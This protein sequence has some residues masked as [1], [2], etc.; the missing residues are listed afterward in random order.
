M[1]LEIIVGLVA[2]AAV[3]VVAAVVVLRRRQPP[4][5]GVVDGAAAAGEAADR[6]VGRLADRAA[7]AAGGPA[8]SLRDRLSKAR[9]VLSGPLTALERTSVSQE[10]WTE[11]TEA[12]IRADVGLAT[13]SEIVEAAR[14]RVGSVGGD[15]TAAKAALQTELRERLGGFDRSLARR[16]DGESPS[17]WLFVGVNGTG[18]TT[19]IGKLAKREA[20]A[21][22]GVVLAAGD[23]FRAAAADQLAMWA[24][25]SS[26]HIVRG[27]A[28][29]DPASVV[30]DAVESAAA[31][32]ADLVLADTAG[33]FHTEH[34][35]MAELQKVRRVA[36]KG[37]GVVT[38]T[39]L[40]LDATTGQN[41]LA[42]A[43]EFAD[44][45]DVT[46]VVLTK[47]DGSAKGGIVVAVQAELGVPVKLV[48]VGEG[49][50]DLVPF[51]TSEFVEALFA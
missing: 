33:R 3:L 17:V 23:T 44:A 43:R 38:E 36:D 12:L 7:G 13:S 41:G 22:S 51:D 26:V 28:G 25:R 29:A 47:L 10:A 16:S 50:A 1:T 37:S 5:P 6:V 20:D 2:L 46:G 40:V 8:P 30:Y 15:P 34:N 32:G 19:T 45:V 9:A 39:L 35:L 11:V 24:E 18:K 21:G 27:S 48:G 4:A 49:I 14:A 31:R 42:Q